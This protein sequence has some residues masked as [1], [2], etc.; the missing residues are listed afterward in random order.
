MFPLRC[1]FSC[2]HDHLA[3]SIRWT[4]FIMQQIVW[5]KHTFCRTDISNQTFW[6]PVCVNRLFSL[7]FSITFREVLMK[8]LF[9]EATPLSAVL[10]YAGRDSSWGLRLCVCVCM[11]VCVCGDGDGWVGGR[12]K[13][14]CCVCECVLVCMLKRVHV[15]Q[16]KCCSPGDPLSSVTQDLA[17]RLASGLLSVLCSFMSAWKTAKVSAEKTAFNW[18]Y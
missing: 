10:H 18:F 9:C 5:L 2:L 14:R 16:Y 3:D 13:K 7:H 1:L 15:D 6:L 12:E 8:R 11:C 17:A 4:L